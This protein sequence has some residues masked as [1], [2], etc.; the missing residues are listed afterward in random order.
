MAPSF[1]HLAKQSQA[2]P[3]TTTTIIQTNIYFPLPFFP[4]PSFVFRPSPLYTFFIFSI[5][6]SISSIAKM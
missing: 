2:K 4:Y 6:L 5:I 3:I 1:D